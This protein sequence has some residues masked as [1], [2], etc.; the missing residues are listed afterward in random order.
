MHRSRAIRNIRLGVKNLLLHKMRSLL[1]VLGVVFGVGS[2]I[3]MLAVGEGASREAIEQIRLLGSNNIIL[4]GIKPVEDVQASVQRTLMSMYGLLYEDEA[5]IR[6]TF[7]YVRQ[8]VA[9]KYVRKNGRLGE[10]SLELRVMG[11]TSDWFD[12]VNREVIAG[13]V[14]SQRD[15]DRHALVC[16]LTEYGVRRL[17]ATEHTVGKSIRI[18]GDYY[19]VVGIIRNEQAGSGI[20][21]PDQKVDAYIPLNVARERYGDMM[22]HRAAGSY[23]RELVELHMI[24][25]QVHENEEVQPTAAAIEAM[26]KRFHKRKDYEISIPLALLRQAEASKRIFNIV[27]GSIAGISL[28]VGG[29][30]IMNIMLASVTER[31]REIGIRR[32]IGAQ[33]NQIIGQFLIEA[34]VL[35]AVGGLIGIGI[36]MIIPWSVTRFTG[37]PTVVSAYGI[38]LSLCISVGVGVV[39]GLYPAIRAANQD[40]IVA[41]RHE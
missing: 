17:L 27:L 32:A 11:T 39:F 16:V 24:L 33:R 23:E 18:G 19:E 34:V 25:V 8:T 36:G 3:A 5:R 29:I 40:P 4:T 30:G 22:V 10:R 37:M 28:L 21:T 31:T 14:L 41:L 9:V 15:I 38:V 6:E 7:P 26:L 2:V 20:Q 13:R 12:L 1:T 35:S